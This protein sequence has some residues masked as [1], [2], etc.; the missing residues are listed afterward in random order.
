MPQG[1]Q[2]Q[3][4]RL[5]LE[6]RLSPSSR[7]SPLTFG[8]L[9]FFHLLDSV[10]SIPFSFPAFPSWTL[11]HSDFGIRAHPLANC[12][13]L[14]PTS[15]CSPLT[16]GSFLFFHI[17]IYIYTHSIYMNNTTC[18]QTSYIPPLSFMFRNPST[19]RPWYQCSSP[20]KLPWSEPQQPLLSVDLRLLTFFPSA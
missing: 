5:Q 8:F 18:L 16:F 19:L 11:Q 20:C 15:R 17:Y 2:G 10:S 9:L 3:S 14:N 1:I 4:Q 6:E 12:L 13:G 7:C